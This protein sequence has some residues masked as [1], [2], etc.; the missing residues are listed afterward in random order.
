M[1]R[2]MWQ[3]LHILRFLRQSE[4]R[5]AVNAEA[6][7]GTAVNT[8][9]V[10]KGKLFGVLL[11]MLIL[12]EIAS[13]AVLFERISR[14]S[15]SELKNVIPLTESIGATK[16][17]VIQQGHATS[18]EQ[19]KKENSFFQP[20]IVAHA[21]PS[22]TA[23]DD[24]TVWQA[25]T[26]VDIFRLT[27]DNES[28]EVTVGG[29]SDN[30]DDLIAPG[31]SGAYRFYLENTGDV[32][33]HYT[34]NME[35]WI[36]GTDLNIPVKASVVSHEGEYLLGNRDEKAEVL[37][38]NTVEDSGAL[39]VDKLSAYT[40][41]WEWPFE[42]GDDTYDTMLGNLAVDNN[43]ALT[44]RINTTATYNDNPEDE[45]AGLDNPQTGDRIPMQLLVCVIVLML[46]LML[47]SFQTGYHRKNE[48]T[49]E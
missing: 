45:D 7:G 24:K 2:H 47:A 12:C 3:C 5:I 28:G 43:L 14:Y 16:V 32:P 15:Q 23:Y 9:H 21:A 17:T 20:Q 37:A 10:R 26:D 13:L 49:N 36:S 35:A 30:S 33:L 27:Y 46:I 8:T 6:K 44:I 22:F 11:V 38:L 18:L 19:T 41:E 42:Q 29:A 34:M 39:G 4:F 40:L 1:C 48:E 31:T 25:E